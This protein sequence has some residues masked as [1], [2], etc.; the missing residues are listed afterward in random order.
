MKRI[1]TM[2]DL[3][4]LGKCSLTVIL[5]VISAM[6]VECT[7]L[8]TAV[9]STHTG[10]PN[11]HV[12]D[13]SEQISPIIEHWS[14]LNVEFSGI[15]TG[16]QANPAQVEIAQS[17]ITRFGGENCLTICDPAMA[18]HGKLYSGLSTEMVSAML[19]LCQ[20]ADLSLP[21]ITEGA[22]LAGLP[23]RES[24]DEGYCR[25]ITQTLHSKG[26]GSVLLTGMEQAPGQT[27]FFWSDGHNTYAHSTARLPR[28]CHGTGDLFAAVVMGAQ[29]RGLDVPKS[30]ALAAEFVKRCIAGT[31]DDSRYGVAF[32]PELKWLAD[33][34]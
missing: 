19:G 6:G 14:T 9:L 3:S 21:N 8:P 27:G 10:F 11:P 20:K 13:L 25:E 17:L 15:L 4:C 7:V 34:L 30:G 31:G 24:A 16:Y 33:Q 12:V 5:P 28:N 2:Q 26:L 29:M 18:D 22:L 32:E 1:L 23:Y